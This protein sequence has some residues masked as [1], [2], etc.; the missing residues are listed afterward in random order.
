MLRELAVQLDHGDIY[1]RDL[2]E[3]NAAL[4]ELLTAFRRHH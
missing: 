2:P 4:T 3:L 1:S